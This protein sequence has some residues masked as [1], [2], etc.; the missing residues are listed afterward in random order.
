M[1]QY[2]VDVPTEMAESCGLML[3][4]WSRL[5]P[6]AAAKTGPGDGPD[7]GEVASRL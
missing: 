3:P 6:A 1:E 7:N 2:R 4:W 5:V